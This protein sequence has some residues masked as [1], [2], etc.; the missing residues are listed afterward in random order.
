M[1]KHAA[2]WHLLEWGNPL[3]LTTCLFDYLSFWIQQ[4]N[5][6]FSV[7]SKTEMR[8]ISMLNW[9]T[10]TC[11]TWEVHIRK[12]MSRLHLHLRGTSILLNDLNVVQNVKM[13]TP[14]LILK[15]KLNEIMSTNSTTSYDPHSNW[16]PF[17][18]HPYT[19]L[20]TCRLSALC[21]LQYFGGSI[22]YA[23]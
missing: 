12:T 20:T 4:R 7:K 8:L 11:Y 5:H 9:Y 18:A 10:Y 22:W 23:E 16:S 6:F 15:M 21:K 2:T 1:R 14:A 17:N 19:S 3:Q 13:T